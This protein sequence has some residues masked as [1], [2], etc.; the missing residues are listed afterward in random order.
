MSCGGGGGGCAIAVSDFATPNG[1]D[2]YFSDN[3]VRNNSVLQ[4]GATDGNGGGCSF[5]ITGE[6][7]L[8][9]NLVYG[10][11]VGDTNTYTTP[12][13]GGLDFE[14]LAGELILTN[15][16]ITQNQVDDVSTTRTG[17]GISF[18]TS[19][20]GAWAPVTV[21]LNNSII[22]NNYG[23]DIYNRVISETGGATDGSEL[24]ISYSNYDSSNYS[25]SPDPGTVTPTLLNNVTNNHPWFSTNADSL[26]HLISDVSPCIDTGDNSAANMPDTDLAGETRPQ[27]GDND[28]RATA[29]MGCYEGGIVFR[30]TTSTGPNGSH[31]SPQ[32]INPGDTA[33]FTFDANSTYH[34]ASISGCGIDYRNTDNSVTS[35][36]E[37]TSAITE[38]CTIS[39]AYA[40]NQYQVTATAG[41]NGA[42]DST[43][44]SPVT[45]NHGA[46]TGFKFNADTGYHVASISG[47]GID[48]TNTDNNIA[49][50]TETTNAVTADCDV[51]ATFAINQ[52]QVTATPG[53]NG[54]LDASTPSPQTIDHGT[55]AQFTFNAAST[56]HIATISGC[57][58][59]YA[60]T[61]NNIS[62]RTETTTAVTADCEVKAAFV[63][64]RYTVTANAGSNGNVD[65]STTITKTEDH[66]TN[67]SFTFW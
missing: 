19:T 21:A 43:T 2:I 50:Q 34:V 5:I 53:T 1:G 24:S 52:Y 29:N 35:R 25:Q 3:I 45:V 18:N 12:D 48:F 58:I 20:A 4:A 26:Y 10:N 30:V 38:N 64:N 16:T 51:T 7:I 15:N 28:G 59:N 65:G 22:Y 41:A 37:T 31:P 33:T 17:A 60:N 49:S 14:L 42:L 40:I 55:T 32:I 44:P 61:D 6:A 9:N 57:V 39:A 54:A 56:Y 63:I 36:E 11:S 46:T 62:S 67:V 13:G 23:D 27:D 8:T 47:C 66:G